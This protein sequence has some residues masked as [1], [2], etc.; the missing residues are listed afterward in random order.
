M[1]PIATCLATREDFYLV[2]L[3]TMRT[4]QLLQSIAYQPCGCFVITTGAIDD[5]AEDGGPRGGLIFYVVFTMS[6]YALE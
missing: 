5:Y 6:L 2:L 1:T 4:K 3:A